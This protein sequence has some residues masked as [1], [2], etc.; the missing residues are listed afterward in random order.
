MTTAGKVGKEFFGDMDSSL[1][2]YIQT[3]DLAELSAENFYAA[4]IENTKGIEGVN[5]V[6]TNF[7]NIQDKSGKTQQ[8]YAQAISQSNANLGNYL[9]NL[10]GAKA[11]LGGYLK[12]LAKTKAATI[13]TRIATT[14]LNATLSTGISFLVSEGLQLLDN[15]IH[16]EEKA[17]EKADELKSKY[18]ETTTALKDNLKTVEGFSDEFNK[19]SKG[20]DEHGNNIGLTTDQYSRYKEIVEQL[21]GINPDLVKVIIEK[22]SFQIPIKTLENSSK[23]II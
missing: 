2:E 10:N 4:Q 18:E 16:S 7:R 13:A 8:A 20:V 22:K 14:A 5:Q 11:G 9:S 12:Y 21:V 23:M 1:K 3:N 6:L 15:W 19:L 17:A